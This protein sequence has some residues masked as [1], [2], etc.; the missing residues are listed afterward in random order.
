MADTV[1]TSRERHVHRGTS[2]VAGWARYLPRP[3]FGQ[4]RRANEM[5]GMGEGLFVAVESKRIN[6][7]R[8]ANGSDEHDFLGK[9]HPPPARIAEEIPHTHFFERF[10]PRLR[11]R[12]ANHVIL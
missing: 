11:R 9:L 10:R 8:G 2:T 5:S 7:N 4:R 3:L 6:P 1:E 12:S